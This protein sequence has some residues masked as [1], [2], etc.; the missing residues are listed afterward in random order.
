[1]PFAGKSFRK[2]QPV[3][4][5]RVH[6]QRLQG[7]FFNHTALKLWMLVTL[8]CASPGHAQT[9]TAPGAPAA[10]REWVSPPPGDVVR[11]QA[12]YQARCT[13]CHNIDSNKIGPAHRGVMGR[14]VGSLPGYKY[15]NE[16]AASRLRWTPQTLNVWLTDPEDLVSGQRMGFQVD[17]AQERADLIA[18]LATLR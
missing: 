11:G 14:R 13:A 1:M 17:D 12:L 5:S 2:R 7:G 6:K 8:V 16:L 4:G 10:P 15:S 18:F 9:A 3:V